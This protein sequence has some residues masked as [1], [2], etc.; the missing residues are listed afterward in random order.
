MEGDRRQESLRK[1]PAVERAMRQMFYPLRGKVVENGVMLKDSKNNDAKQTVLSIKLYDELFSVIHNVP[2]APSAKMNKDSGEACT[3]ETG[4]NVLVSF[5]GGD[6]YDPMVTSFL[7]AAD[8]TIQADASEAPRY[9]RKFRGTSEKI[10]KDG[11]RTVY[12][13]AGDTLEVVGDGAVTIGGKLTVTVTGAVTLIA[14]TIKLGATS[15]LF[16][17]IKETF[18]TFFNAHIHPDPVSGNSGPPTI[19]ADDTYKTEN[20]TAK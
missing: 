15:G 19:L 5:I 11:N 12:V 3:P 8:N 20:V 2:I 13:A 14:D 4:D 16:A 9:Y 17:L 7:P 18:L 6:F 10:D 1:V